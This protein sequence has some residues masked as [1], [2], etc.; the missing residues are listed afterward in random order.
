MMVGPFFEEGERVNVEEET[1]NLR[2]K[3]KMKIEACRRRL[4][5]KA[6]LRMRLL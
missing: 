6:P 5:D 4:F 3:T 1:L 2:S